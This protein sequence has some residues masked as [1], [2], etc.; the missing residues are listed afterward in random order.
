MKV[1]KKTE[2]LRDVTT[3][4]HLMWQV[5]QERNELSYPIVSNGDFL[6]WMKL[7]REQSKVI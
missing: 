6:L 2:V 3:Q 4:L 5:Q 7:Q 1:S